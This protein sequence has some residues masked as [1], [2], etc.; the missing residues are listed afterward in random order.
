MRYTAFLLGVILLFAAGA[1]AQV[2]PQDS[3]LLASADPGTPYAATLGLSPALAQPSSQ[4]A[5][6]QPSVYGVFQN[7]NW[8]VSGGY[9]FVRF[10]VVP[11]VTTN[12]NAINIGMVYYPHGK[13]IGADGE[14]EGGWGSIG[15]VSSKL[16]LIM[17]GP[18][19]RWSAPR[20]IELWAHGL[21]G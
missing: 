21:V 14:F 13:W 6:Q 4:P 11:K 3:T 1:G 5:A 17:G 10:Y 8:Q 15:G 20:A 2:N 9:T 18:R 7:Y 12:M 16:A 19:F